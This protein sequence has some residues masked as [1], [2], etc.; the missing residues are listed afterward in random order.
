VLYTADLAVL[1]ILRSIAEDGW[2]RPIYFAGTVSQSSELGLQDYFQNEGLARRVVPL[3][4]GGGDPDGAVVPEVALA[5]LNN[6]QF[7]GLNDPDVYLDQNARNMADGYR[8]RLGSIATRLAE[9]G[10]TDAA[11]T[12]LD[13]LETEVPFETVTPS[14]GSLLTLAD[15]YTRSGNQEMASMVLRQAEDLSLAQLEGASASG[16]E[17]AFQFVQYVQSAYIVGGDYEAASAFMGRIADVIGDERFRRT[18][19]QIRVEAEAMRPPPA[20]EASSE[21]EPAAGS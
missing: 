4:R 19:E 12:V 21:P 20:S 3:A 15:A 14:F 7:R 17:Q 8:I 5:R 13:R 6:F 1:D 16:Q 2:K 10:N 9:Q 18:P 11:R